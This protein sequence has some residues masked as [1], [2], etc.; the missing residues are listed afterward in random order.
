MYNAQKEEMK[1]D[2]NADDNDEE[3]DDLHSGTKQKMPRR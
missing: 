2:K 1:E 3:R